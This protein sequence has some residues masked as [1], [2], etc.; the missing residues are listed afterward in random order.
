[1]KYLIRG[2]GMYTTG[3]PLTEFMVIDNKLFPMYLIGHYYNR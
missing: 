3:I 2:T 1:M